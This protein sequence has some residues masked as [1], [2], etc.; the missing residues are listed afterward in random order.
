MPDAIRDA[1]RQQG[2]TKFVLVRKHRDYANFQF[3]NG[4][5]DGAGKLE[6]LGFYLDGTWETR[7]VDQTTGAVRAGRGF[8]AP[9]AYLEVVLIDFPS[10]RV[11]GKKSSTGSFQVGA[12]RALQDIAEPWSALTSVEKVGL[13]NQLI[14]REVSSAVQE[15][16]TKAR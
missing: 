4:Y 9:F 10:G 6:G 11:M 15:I 2:A 1:L 13:I 14:E 5:S 12:G 16:F 7:S 8:I 3:I